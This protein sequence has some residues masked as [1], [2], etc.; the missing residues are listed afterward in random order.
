MEDGVV[1]PFKIRGQR[2]RKIV[3]NEWY[4]ESDQVK[5][6]ISTELV[7]ILILFKRRELSENDKKK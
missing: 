5:I 3:D 4:K 1:K 2:N 7:T 6:K